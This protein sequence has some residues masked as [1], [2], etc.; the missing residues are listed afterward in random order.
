MIFGRL[1]RLGKLPRVKASHG[2]PVARLLGDLPLDRAVGGAARQRQER[3]VEAVSKPIVDVVVVVCDLAVADVE[4]EVL[5]AVLV[6]VKK[7]PLPERAVLAAH[8][9]AARGLVDL[10]HSLVAEAR[11]TASPLPA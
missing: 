8:P 5:V 3:L 4:A 10:R 6:F 1:Q 9:P 2:Q 7:L 11:L